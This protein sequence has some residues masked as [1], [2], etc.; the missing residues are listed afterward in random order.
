MGERSMPST[1]WGLENDSGP[2]HKAYPSP[3]ELLCCA[4]VSMQLGSGM[5]ANLPISKHHL[6]VPQPMSSTR[7]G[8]LSGANQF[9][10][11]NN[12]FMIACCMSSRSRSGYMVEGQRA[13]LGGTGQRVRYLV[14]GKRISY[15]GSAFGVERRRTRDCLPPAM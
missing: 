9:F 7:F 3:W 6:P 15:T 2:C 10:C 8:R 4:T 1:C 13:D 12:A 11:P 5:G 14:V